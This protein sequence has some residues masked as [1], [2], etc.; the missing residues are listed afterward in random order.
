MDTT[1]LAPPPY[2]R[3]IM[4]SRETTARLSGNRVE[5]SDRN[6]PNRTHTPG[7]CEQSL[8]KI[9]IS[10]EYSAYLP[11]Q[12]ELTVCGTI[13]VDH[14][15]RPPFICAKVVLS[16]AMAAHPLKRRFDAASRML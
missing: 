2:P 14:E 11:G 10:R 12:P 8:V 4:P 6:E 1:R 5:A 3:S 9:R 13:G 7:H 16:I 15:L